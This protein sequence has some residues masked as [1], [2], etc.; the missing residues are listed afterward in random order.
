MHVA[1][2]EAML[3]YYVQLMPTFLKET[4]ETTGKD[5]EDSHD[6]SSAAEETLL[7]ARYL[8]SMRLADVK[9]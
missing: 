8:K 5:S 3:K 9:M 6:Y 4:A 7:E 1:T 2:A